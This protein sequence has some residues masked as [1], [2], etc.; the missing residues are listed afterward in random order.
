MVDRRGVYDVLAV[1]LQFGIHPSFFVTAHYLVTT[2][3]LS[4]VEQAEGG[5]DLPAQFHPRY[6]FALLPAVGSSDD[7]A[8][9]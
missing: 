6:P 3:Y 1:T 7:C 8:G 9:Q 5:P 2:S 4:H